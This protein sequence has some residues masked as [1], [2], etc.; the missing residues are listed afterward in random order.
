MEVYNLKTVDDLLLSPEE[1]V[2]LINGEI[3]RRPMARPEHGA[4]Q[5]RT[6]VELGRVNGICQPRRLVDHN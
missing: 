5:N 1:R 2:E 3:V 4:V 6:P